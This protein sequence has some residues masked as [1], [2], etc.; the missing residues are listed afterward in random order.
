M[1]RLIWSVK[2]WATQKLTVIE[3][4]TKAEIVFNIRCFAYSGIGDGVPSE[5]FLHILARILAKIARFIQDATQD[6]KV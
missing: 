1:I 6:T 5:K 4:L 3:E 2:Q